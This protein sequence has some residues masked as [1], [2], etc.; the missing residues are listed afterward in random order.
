MLWTLYSI[1]TF[2]LRIQARVHSLLL[3][4]SVTAVVVLLCYLTKSCESNNPSVNALISKTP[5]CIWIRPWTPIWGTS[6]VSAVPIYT[7]QWV[8]TI[9]QSERGINYMNSFYSNTSET[10]ARTTWH[11]YRRAGITPG[12]GWD[13]SQAC[14]SMPA[15]IPPPPPPPPPRTLDPDAPAGTRTCRRR[16]SRSWRWG[17]GGTSRRQRPAA[18]PRWA[19]GDAPAPA[20]LRLLDWQGSEGGR[21]GICMRTASLRLPW[22]ASGAWHW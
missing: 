16:R 14:P 5:K 17:P 18:W 7:T 6:L 4:C 1:F 2:R 10:F 20:A 15:A 21:L 22:L 19:P 11:Y 9:S 12:Q 3:S 13:L 8:K